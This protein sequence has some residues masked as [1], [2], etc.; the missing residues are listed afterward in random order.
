MDISNTLGGYL[1]GRLHEMGLRH[2]FGIPGDY[3]L[4]LYQMIED[5][6]IQNVGTTR[7]DCAGFAAD[8]Y[9]RIHGI[10]AFC[11]T[12]CVGGLGAVNAVA[13][14]YAERSPVVLLSGSPGLNERGRSP[15]LH[16]MVKDFAT[17]RDV[18]EKVTV[19]SVILDD[20]QTA[21]RQIDMAL[22]ALQKHKR[23]VYLEV[24]RDL[25]LAPIT[26]PMPAPPAEETSDP[27]ALAEALAEVSAML[28]AAR[29]PVVLAG[30]DVQRFGVQEE[31]VRIVERLNAPVASTLMGK[32]VIRED[33]PLYVGIYGGLIGREAVNSFVEGADCV[34]MLGSVLTDLDLG[35]PGLPEARV[36]HA[37][38]GRV[39]VKRHQYGDVRFQDFMRAL[40]HAPLTPAAPRPLPPPEEN[41][42][43]RPAA[44]EAA[45]LAGVFG[46]LD[47]VLDE[48]MVVIA[49][50]GEA[51]VC[52]RRPARAAGR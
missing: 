6:P 15:F 46:A 32:S 17:Q 50:V 43:P 45:T 42:F 21:P 38:A 9:A 14:A 27:D 8:A 26:R 37:A 34:L 31:L 35:G 13:S 2:M 30:A 33:H 39:A 49:D 7:E 16:H 23:P 3:V 28:A 22:A 29:R 20:P 11:V 52:R 19:A 51:P 40:A 1:L 5:S 41:V 18:F 25:V 44:E 48:N 47:D 36:V 24:P 10:G 12:Y 4:G